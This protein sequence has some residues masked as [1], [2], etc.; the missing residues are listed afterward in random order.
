MSDFMSNCSKRSVTDRMDSAEICGAR[1]IL[2]HSGSLLIND[3]SR[4]RTK[5]DRAIAVKQLQVAGSWTAPA[6]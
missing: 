2:S 4:S 5:S 1:A 6:R 3:R